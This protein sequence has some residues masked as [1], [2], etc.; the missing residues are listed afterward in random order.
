MWRTK[1]ITSN[2]FRCQVHV[3]EAAHDTAG[4]FNVYLKIKVG[5]RAKICP[6]F[7]TLAVRKITVVESGSSDNA[8]WR[9]NLEVHKTYER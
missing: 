7:S 3:F 4:H 1:Q 5:G 8:V 6:Y 9:D 2:L